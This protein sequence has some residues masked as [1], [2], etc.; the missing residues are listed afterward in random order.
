MINTWNP[1]ERYEIEFIRLH[2][3]S[4]G[5]VRSKNTL[6]KEISNSAWCFVIWG[7][8]GI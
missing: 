6:L 2:I 5:P 7:F 1:G 8:N 4:H 3:S